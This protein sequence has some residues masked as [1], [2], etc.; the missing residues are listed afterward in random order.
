MLGA[1]QS[2]QI[3]GALNIQ[4]LFSHDSSFRKSKIRQK[5]I[6]LHKL[7]PDPVFGLNLR[8]EKISKRLL[9]IAI[10]WGLTKPT[11]NVPTEYKAEKEKD[12]LMKFPCL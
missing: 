7:Q 3:L 4:V 5:M 9:I 12:I 2:P 8:P 1:S 11:P 6:Y 10:G